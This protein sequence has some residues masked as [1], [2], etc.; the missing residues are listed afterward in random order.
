MSL[1]AHTP[2]L[3]HHAQIRAQ[4]WPEFSMVST[5]YTLSMGTYWV[6][7]NGAMSSKGL[8][9]SLAEFAPPRFRDYLRVVSIPC[10]AAI[11]AVWLAMICCARRATSGFFPDSNTICAMATA[12]S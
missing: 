11:S 1:V 9:Q 6:R 10:M 4:I 8:W 3:P 2:A 7:R 5:L 12:P